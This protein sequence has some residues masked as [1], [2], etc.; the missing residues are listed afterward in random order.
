MR[1]FGAGKTPACPNPSGH[2]FLCIYCGSEA[3]PVRGAGRWAWPAA[4]SAMTAAAAILLAMLVTRWQLPITGPA[5]EQ[6]TATPAP[7][8][9]QH[10]ASPAAAEN[11]H[12][13]NTGRRQRFAAPRVWSRRGNVLLGLA[14]SGA[15]RRGGVVEVPRFAGG[16]DRPDGRCGRTAPELSRTIESFA[17]TAGLAWF[18]IRT[19]DSEISTR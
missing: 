14:G 2:R 5:G 6:G 17:G 3:A 11:G 13:Q 19:A 7:L 16:R 18:V 15:P 4:L 8:L 9:A 10:Q 1:A 12:G